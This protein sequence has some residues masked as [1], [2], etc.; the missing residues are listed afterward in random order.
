MAIANGV[1]GIIG[2]PLNPTAFEAVYLK[3]KGLDIPVVNTAVD[4]PENTRLAFVGTDTIQMGVNAAMAIIEATGGEANVAVLC[5]ALDTGNQLSSFN[6]FV[7]YC[8]KNAPGVKV[9][10]RE[11]DDSDMLKAIDKTESILAAYPEVNVIYCLEAAAGP[12]AAKVIE[13]KGLQ[14]KIVI[15]AVDDTVDTLDYIK[16]GII[17]GTITQNFFK[18]GY[19]AVKFIVEYKLNGTIPPSITDSGTVLVTKENIDTYKK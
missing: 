4:S 6:A 2:C 3:A 17:Y 13:E 1:D 8:A 5:T 7:D 12:G 9:V 18:M 19:D 10:V 15:L 14:D 11:A 16:K